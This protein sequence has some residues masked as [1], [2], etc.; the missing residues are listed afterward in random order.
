MAYYKEPPPGW[1]EY[2]VLPNAQLLLAQLLRAHIF[3]KIK[4]S[5][6]D[7]YNSYRFVADTYGTSWYHSHYGSQLLDGIYGPLVIYG[8]SHVHFDQDLG[9]IMIQDCKTL[10]SL[11][12]LQFAD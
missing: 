11:R 1:M 8:P 3:L 4:T 7:I 12:F 6:A 5:I 10:H 2:R 9:P